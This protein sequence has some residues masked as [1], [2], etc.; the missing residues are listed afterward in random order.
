MYSESHV[1]KMYEEV[2]KEMLTFYEIIIIN[3]SFCQSSV[4]AIN[5]RW[6]FIKQK[7]RQMSSS[8]RI[9]ESRI[10][11]RVSIYMWE[12][13]SKKDVIWEI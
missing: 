3:S 1:E 10:L 11:G 12:Q 6:Q 7:Y 8:K 2:I 5:T 13:Y 9:E 4:H